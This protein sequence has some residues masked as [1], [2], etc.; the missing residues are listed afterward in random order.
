MD[1]DAALS[2]RSI[3][4]LLQVVREN[5]PTHDRPLRLDDI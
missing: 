2:R 1:T 3:A 5:S 4:A